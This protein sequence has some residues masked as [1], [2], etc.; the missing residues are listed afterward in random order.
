M[1]YHGIGDVALQ[2]PGKRKRRAAVHE[3]FHLAATDCLRDD[4]V[5]M[6]RIGGKR[7]DRAHDLR[8]GNSISVIFPEQFSHEN[9]GGIVCQQRGPGNGAIVR[10]DNHFGPSIGDMGATSDLGWIG[11]RKKARVTTSFE[12]CRAFDY[13]ITDKYAA[14]VGKD[15]VPQAVVKRAFGNVARKERPHLAAVIIGRGKVDGAPLFT[16]LIA[17]AVECHQHLA[18]RRICRTEQTRATGQR[19]AGNIDL[20]QRAGRYAMRFGGRIGLPCTGSK[21][22]RK[23]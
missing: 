15:H 3:L 1:M 10:G 9:H 22:A 16:A 23:A 7:I 20:V 21:G 8:L 13:K 11:D 12:R 19:H 17:A 6:L 18:G 5:G 14:V 2:E 4:A